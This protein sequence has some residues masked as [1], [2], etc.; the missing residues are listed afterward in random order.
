VQL[1]PEHFDVALTWLSGRRVP[2]EDPDDDEAADER[3]NFGFALGEMGERPYVYATC[4]PL[5]DAFRG[6]GLP[7]FARWQEQGWR[8][9]RIDY[10]D[11]R[12]GDVADPELLALLERLRGVGEAALGRA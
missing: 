1:R 4:H 7:A 6:A 12:E 2:G 8:G 10:D 11:L 9:V 5:V 3:M